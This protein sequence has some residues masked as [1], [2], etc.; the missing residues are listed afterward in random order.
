MLSDSVLD[1]SVAAQQ[2]N[3]KLDDF[4]AT[5]N[6][7][8]QPMFM[9]IRKGMSEDSGQQYLALVSRTACSIYRRCGHGW[10]V[11]EQ[12]ASNM[13]KPTSLCTESICACLF[14]LLFFYLV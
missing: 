9:Q 5:I 12:P 4:I 8:L 3:D 2:S 6:S 1:F 11:E 13:T 14:S 10:F 7:A